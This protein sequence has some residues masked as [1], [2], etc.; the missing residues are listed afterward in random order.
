MPDHVSQPRLLLRRLHSVMASG[1]SAEDRLRRVVQVI[2]QNMVAE[3]CS[4]YLRRA[5]SIL[6]LFATEGLKEEAVHLT[7]LRFGEG[8]VGLVAERGMPLNLSEAP[9]HPKFAYRPETGED[10]YHS[11]L[12]VPILRRSRVAGVLVVQN[13]ASRRYKTEEIEALQ[14]IAMVISELVGSTE[15]IAPE[16]LSEDSSRAGGPITVDGKR[17]ASGIGAGIAVFHEPQVQISKTVADDV[18]EESIRLEEAIATL[19]LQLENML[20]HPDLEHGGEHREV[21]ETYRMFAYDQGWQDKMRE[22][23]LSGLTAEAAVDKVQQENRIRM[24]KIR[25]PYLRERLADFE[26]LATRLIRII[27]GKTDPGHEKLEEDSVLVARNIGP[28]EL[29]D[30]DR[31]FLK[32]IVMEEGSTTAHVTIIARAMG[33]PVLGQVTGLLNHVESGEYIVVDSDHEHAYVRPTEDIIESYRDAMELRVK[34]LA[35]YAAERDLPATTLDGENVTLLMNAGLLVDLPSLDET[36]AEGIGLF[37]TEFQFM[38]SPALPR[39]DEQTKIYSAAIEAAGD[40]PVV[41]RTLDIGG[42]KPVPFLPREPEENPAMGWRAIRIALDRPA[43]LRYQL[44]ALLYSA[45]GK[46][47]HVMFPMIAEVAEL[48]RCKKILQ[49]EID[50]LDRLGKDK[51]VA[52]KVGVM[53]EVPSLSW[54]LDILLREIDFLSIGTNDLMQFFFACDRSNPKLADRYDLMAPPVLAFLHSVVRACHQAGVPVTLCGEMGGRPLE[55]M[56]LIALGLRRLSISPSAMGPVKR[57]IRSVDLKNL[58]QFMM[59]NITSPEHSIRDSLLLFA[60]D[61]NI[62]L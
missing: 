33:I 32:A 4:I 42:D 46:T 38:V 23:V 61:H 31:S 60:R 22:T 40:R 49:K 62:R 16:E 44:R 8:L 26:D 5:G 52:V 43:L 6:E 1:G 24:K 36:G 14:T 54:Q 25:D 51:P 45:A 55:A 30:Y 3:V 19:R 2:A 58:R 59:E 47:L 21:L 18:D 56:A 13:V 10:I 9:S 39:V 15:V 50:R 7:R 28:A 37:R 35:E 29:M 48:R 53:L 20:D 34:L 27:Q 57:M 11:F 41:F 12:G 17:L